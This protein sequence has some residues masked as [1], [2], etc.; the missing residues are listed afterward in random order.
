ML[1][2]QRVALLEGVVLSEYVCIGWRKCVT[3]GGIWVS[4]TQVRPAVSPFL[5]LPDCVDVELSA[6]SP[7]PCLPGGCMLPEMTIMN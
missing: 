1:G 6:T 7:A 3:G 2:Y 5:L 4:N